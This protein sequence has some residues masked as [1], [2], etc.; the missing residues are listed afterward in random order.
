[1]P[2]MVAC[3][4][5]TRP[6]VIKMA[7]VVAS[8]RRCGRLDVRL[9]A[10]GQHRELLDT[11]LADFG[12]WA[13]IDLD[14]MRPGQGLA[15]LTART[16]AGLGERFAHERPALV[17]AQ[18]DTTTVLAAALAAHYERIP[19]GHVEAGLRSGR[20]DSPFPEETNRVLVARLA[21]LHFAPTPDAARNLRIEGV[22]PRSIRVTGNPVVDALRLMEGRLP[23]PPSW[24]PKRYLL[25]TVHRRENQGPPLERIA[26]ALRE[27]L[28]RHDGLGLVLPLHPNPAVSGPI[29]R[30]LGGL[31][32]VHLVEPLGYPQFLAVLRRAALVLSDS[33]GVQEEGPALGLRVLILR[34]TTER[35][36]AVRGG[37]ARLV[38]TNPERIVA[39]AERYLA[40]GL[41][42]APPPANPFGDGRAGD[43]IALA[44]RHHLGLPSEPDRNPPPP[45][46]AAPKRARG[47][48]LRLSPSG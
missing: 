22:D 5:G 13:D 39:E 33:G 31:A 9:V 20:A 37:L 44:V 42:S 38:G 3:V 14:L 8:L 28:R 2:P 43:R 46:P 45:W 19:F 18:G 12:L 24:L 34:D 15:E 27:L 41:S 48:S 1:M 23:A 47:R 7:P 25:A 17:L 21:A 40:E 26:A 29:R 30:A 35:P 36:E 11:A 10:T 6:E 32:R 4:V 16:L